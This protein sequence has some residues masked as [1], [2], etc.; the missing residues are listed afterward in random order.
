MR[1]SNLLKLLSIIFAFALIAAACGGDDDNSGSSGDSSVLG[2]ES[3]EEEAP[4]EEREMVC[5][6][7]VPEPETEDEVVAASRS[8]FSSVKDTAVVQPKPVLKDGMLYCPTCGNH[9]RQNGAFT[10]I[11]GSKETEGYWGDGVGGLV[12]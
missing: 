12:I 7:C 11:K 6:D 10:K 1:K 2:E 3:S 5:M 8:V 4:A 9:G